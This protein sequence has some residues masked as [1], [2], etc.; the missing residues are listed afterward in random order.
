MLRISLCMIVKNEGSNL[1]ACLNSVKELV[2]EIVIVDTGST[3]DTK[4]IALKYTDK[5]YEYEWNDDFS[6]ARNYSFTKATMQYILW[7]DADDVLLV[8]DQEKLRELKNSSERGIDAYSMIYNYSFDDYGNL[9][10]CFRRNRLVKR[11]KNFKWL[12]RVHEYLSVNGDI[13]NTDICVTHT[14]KM[15]HSMRNIEIYKKQLEA[16][17]ALSTR[18]L[19]YYAK[20]LLLEKKDAEAIELLKYFLKRGDARNEDILSAYQL[21]AYSCLCIRDY[22]GCRRYCFHTFEYEQPRSD[23]C[24]LIGNSFMSEGR[25]IDAVFWYELATKSNL[26]QNMKGWKRVNPSC[27]TWLPHLQLC[28]CYYQ[29]GKVEEACRHNEMAAKYAPQR[30]SIKKNKAFFE[31][32]GDKVGRKLPIKTS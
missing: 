16:G 5:V 11:N 12:G 20:E 18:D 15:K 25:Y 24:C 31:S 14:G 3:D 17:I 21:I 19:Y 26:N 30:D 27:Y 2:D 29:L 32:I 8:K 6:K 7:L 1:N 22:V 4:E 9:S 10:L 23:I 13:Y 28:V